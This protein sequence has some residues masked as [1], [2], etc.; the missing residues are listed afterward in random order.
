MWISVAAVANLL[1]RGI[2][3][4]LADLDDQGPRKYRALTEHI[5]EGINARKVPH[6]HDRSVNR[7]PPFSGGGRSTVN[8]YAHAMRIRTWLFIGF[9]AVPIIEIALFYSV[10]TWIGIWPT[11]GIV[12]ITAVL[13]SYF[14]SR[15][16]RFVWESIKSKINQGEIPTG[17]V[18]HGAMILIAGALLLTP[19]FLTDIV[20]FSLL[21]PGVREALRQWFLNRRE[22]GWVVVE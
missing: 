3:R 5:S 7:C 22:S 4:A 6:F 1:P 2:D 11:L 12:V 18:V 21:V 19:G 10:G 15:Q 13:G 8:G 16:G 14:V 20:G 9:L 17:T